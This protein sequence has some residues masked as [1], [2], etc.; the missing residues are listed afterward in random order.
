M[1]GDADWNRQVT[2]RVGPDPR[3]SDA[4]AR[5]VDEI[6]KALGEDGCLVGD[7]VSIGINQPPDAVVDLVDGAVH[8]QLAAFDDSN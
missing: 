2:I 6:I 5:S 8:Q 1:D 3:L 7:S 4:G